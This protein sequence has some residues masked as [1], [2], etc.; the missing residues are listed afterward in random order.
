MSQKLNIKKLRVDFGMSQN[1]LAERMGVSRPTIARIEE[2]TRK[3]TIKEQKQIEEIFELAQSFSDKTKSDIRIDIPQKNLD[4]FKQVLLYVL[5]KTGGKS[6][7]GMTVLYKLLYFIDFDYYE[8]YHEQLMGLT[9]IKNHHGPTPKEF[10]KVM[11]EMKRGEEIVEIKNKFFNHEQ[12]KFLPLSK[13][14]LSILTIREK[15]MIDNVLG[16]YSDKTA[17]ELST[18]SHIDTPWA[19]A[20]KAGDILKYE[21]VFYRP[22]EL[23]VGVYEEL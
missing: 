3:L 10:V 6:N 20:E 1:E 15:E 18:I 23:S 14:D 21:H 17:T 8:K 5:E 4:K 9:Y 19:V 22:A 2:G 11:E 16:R 7:V 13:A 12:K